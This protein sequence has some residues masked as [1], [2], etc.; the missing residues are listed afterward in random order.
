MYSPA[1]LVTMIEGRLRELGMTQAQLGQHAFGRADNTA[2]QSLKKGSSPAI[3]RLE[4]MAK[5]LG[6]EVYFGPP[7]PKDVPAMHLAEAGLQTDLQKVDAFRAG[8][9]PLPWV[10][11]KTGAG[12]A[13]IAFAYQWLDAN[14]LIPDDL[15]C[16]LPDAVLIDGIDPA[17]MLAIIDRRATR[18]GFG[19]WAIE[20]ARK[21][22]IAR[23]LVSDKMLVLQPPDLSLPPKTVPDWRS[24]ETRVLGRVVWIGYRPVP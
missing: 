17:K 19:L 15:A 10:N 13:P 1:E 7:R 12:S 14:G 21:C 9:L 6:W 20:D 2:I 23:A 11:A 3:D 4:A 22:S 5:A 16:L 24:T 8:Y 18:S